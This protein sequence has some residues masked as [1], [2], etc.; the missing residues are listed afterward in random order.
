M[1][2]DTIARLAVVEEKIRA[3]SN[4]IEAIAHLDRERAER[5]LQAREDRAREM[6]E[7]RSQLSSY[8]RRLTALEDAQDAAQPRTESPSATIRQAARD[9]EV[10]ARTRLWI[11]LASTITAGGAG[12]ILG[13]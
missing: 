8:I 3:A 7:I 10:R 11:A 1:D 2:A 5:E 4:A 13:G 6:G 12:Y 9:E